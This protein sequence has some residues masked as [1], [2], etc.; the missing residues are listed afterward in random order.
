[1]FWSHI[2]HRSDQFTF[3]EFVES[4]SHVDDVCGECVDTADCAEFSRNFWN[5]IHV[6]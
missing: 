6:D 1:M 3:I 5:V 2:F 4:D